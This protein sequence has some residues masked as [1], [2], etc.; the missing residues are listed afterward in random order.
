MALAPVTRTRMSDQ[1]FAQLKASILDGTLPAGEL[2]PTEHELCDLF[3]TSRTAVREAVRQLELLG[4][5]DSRQGSRRRVRPRD[6][7]WTLPLLRDLLVP[8]G[9][10]DATT[11]GHFLEV[12]RDFMGVILSRAG[13]AGGPED[14]ARLRE[15]ADAQRHETDR[16]AFVRRELQ[17]ALALTGCTGNPVHSMVM[18]SFI[19][20]VDLLVPRIVDLIP[21][22]TFETPLYD[23]MIDALEAGEAEAL[24]PVVRQVL[25]EHDAELVRLLLERESRKVPRKESRKNRD[26]AARSSS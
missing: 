13:A 4:M 8:A 15:I 12:R 11:L 1:V 16:E 22:T 6:E 24:R 2:L 14:W 26:E 21:D 23:P 20:A 3:D 19:D 7:L 10:P 9:E 25:E 5:V 17:F 18:R